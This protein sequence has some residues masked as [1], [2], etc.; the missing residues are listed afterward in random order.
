MFG[1]SPVRREQPSSRLF[2][3]GGSGGASRAEQGG[4]QILYSSQRTATS[5]RGPFRAGSAGSSERLFVE[6]NSECRTESC[7][8]R[9]RPVLRNDFFVEKN[10]ECRTESCSRWR[11]PVLRDNFFVEKNSECGTESGSRW[12]QPILRDK[13]N[14]IRRK[15]NRN[16]PLPATSRYQGK[17]S[18]EA[19]CGTSVLSGLSLRAEDPE[20]ASKAN[21]EVGMA[22]CRRRRFRRCDGV[23]LPGPAAAS[24]WEGG[25]TVSGRRPVPAA[26]DDTAVARKERRSGCLVLLVLRSMLLR[27]K[28]RP[29]SP[30]RAEGA[31]RLRSAVNPA[32]GRAFGTRFEGERRGRNDG[33]SAEA[34]SK[35]RRGSAARSGCGRFSCVQWR[36][37]MSLPGAHFSGRNGSALRRCLS[38]FEPRFA[39]GFG[40]KGWPGEKFSLD[41]FSRKPRCGTRSGKPDERSG[42]SFL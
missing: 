2:P 17:F 36:A 26:C 18:P 15:N 12:R 38:R 20:P 27:R 30:E 5:G 40:R 13:C 19:C 28:M 1:P 25:C 31:V 8:R 37:D 7:S 9:R 42:W 14:E 41:L 33:V 32:V 29:L 34:V 35:V 10:S 21:D 3:A 22:A 23:Q 39:F 16:P 6:K 11:R 4:A 24:R